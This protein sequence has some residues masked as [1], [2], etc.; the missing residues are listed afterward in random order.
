MVRDVVLHFV[1]VRHKMDFYLFTLGSKLFF[2]NSFSHV[3]HRKKPA[4]RILQKK[5][6]QKI[7]HQEG[8]L[9]PAS[10]RPTNHTR[11]RDWP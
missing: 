1:K 7:Q 11:T 4:P 8:H 9:D 6:G 10:Q 2:P 5:K 3:V